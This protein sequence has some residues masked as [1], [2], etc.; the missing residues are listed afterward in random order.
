MC[1]YAPRN[2]RALRI[3]APTRRDD[4]MCSQSIL[5]HNGPHA[6]VNRMVTTTATPERAHLWSIVYTQKVV[7]FYVVL[8]CAGEHAELSIARLRAPRE[9]IC[10]GARA[11]HVQHGAQHATTKP[12]SAFT[13]SVQR[14]R[15]IVAIIIV[16]NHQRSACMRRAC[17]IRACII[18]LCV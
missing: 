12:A 13:F 17:C 11:K 7:L 10:L 14:S 1:I 16:N 2:K 9:C 6:R 8:S 4:Q 18:F 5:L 3:A 15:S